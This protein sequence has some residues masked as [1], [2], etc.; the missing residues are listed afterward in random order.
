MTAIC[1]PC[2]YVNNPSSKVPGC[3]LRSKPKRVERARI[4][5]HQ[6]A[7]QQDFS[8]D[9]TFEPNLLDRYTAHQSSFELSLKGFPTFL[10]PRRTPSPHLWPAPRP[11]MQMGHAPFPLPALQPSHFRLPRPQYYLAFILESVQLRLCSM[12]LFPGAVA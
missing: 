10:P 11:I 4:R 12:P 2:I 7:I 6:K 1:D 9:Q 8:K 3:R 5:H